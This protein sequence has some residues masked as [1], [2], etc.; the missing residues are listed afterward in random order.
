MEFFEMFY[1]K[2]KSFTYDFLENFESYF[3]KNI[4]M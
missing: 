3:K 1:W 2:G 4:D